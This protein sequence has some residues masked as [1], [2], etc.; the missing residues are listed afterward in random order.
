MFLE[1][2]REDTPVRGLNG[3]PSSRARGSGLEMLSLL[4]RPPHTRLPHSRVLSDTQT[5]PCA[6]SPVLPPLPQTRPQPRAGT[7]GRLG[8]A[9]ARGRQPACRGLRW[10]PAARADL[11]FAEGHGS[12]RV[13]DLADGF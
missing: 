7:V 5:R 2:L 12:S 10:G 13:T 4:V 9:N 6:Q 8:A 3:F 1:G 11:V